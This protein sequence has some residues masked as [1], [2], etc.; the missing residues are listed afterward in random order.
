ML[1]KMFQMFFEIV[2]EHTA[3]IWEEVSKSY[4]PVYNGLAQSPL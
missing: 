3:G 1:C 4:K 2:C